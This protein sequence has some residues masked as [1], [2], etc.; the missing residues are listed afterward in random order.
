MGLG[1]MGKK[2][3]TSGWG[4]GFMS[5]CKTGIHFWLRDEAKP[6][7]ISAIILYT[8][9]HDSEHRTLIL[10]GEFLSW[11]WFPIR[12]YGIGFFQNSS[13]N[14]FIAAGLQLLP[15]GSSKWLF[16]I[17]SGLT[18]PSW[19]GC[20]GV[21]ASDNLAW[22]DLWACWVHGALWPRAWRWL[23]NASNYSHQSPA[24]WQ[25]TLHGSFPSGLSFRLCFFSSG[26]APEGSLRASTAV[27]TVPLPEWLPEVLCPFPWDSSPVTRPALRPRTR[28][29]GRDFAAWIPNTLRWCHPVPT[30]FWG[31]LLLPP[32]PSSCHLP[33]PF[34]LL[35]LTQD[36]FSE[37][38]SWTVVLSKPHH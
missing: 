6:P 27:D 32:G 10:Y 3:K 36:I 7:G 28:C 29:P 22:A 25:L 23:G 4:W 34:L 19:V 12:A 24:V 17:S 18:T 20:I 15:S 5:S 8:K 33:G 38:H 14:S 31:Y 2:R 16:S 35:S 1:G 21:V 13:V 11:L 30:I 26:S 37:L 9:L